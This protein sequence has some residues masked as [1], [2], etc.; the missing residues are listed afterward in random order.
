MARVNSK[1]KKSELPKFVLAVVL[2]IVLLIVV[3]SQFAGSTSIAGKDERNTVT[4]NAISPPAAAKQT[5]NRL[6]VRKINKQATPSQHWP[7]AVAPAFDLPR[8]NHDEIAAQNPFFEIPVTPETLTAQTKAKQSEV[9]AA[10]DKLKSKP[11]I[12]AVYLTP[13]GATALVDGQLV[14]VEN[15]LP[16]IDA[17]K[18]NWGN[19]F[20]PSIGATEN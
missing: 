13:Q 11:K 16:A 3:I 9:L 5:A 18:A 12:D 6:N 17:I 4:D 2:A 20:S 15:P 1:R 8:T 10:D 19:D 14:P 7:A